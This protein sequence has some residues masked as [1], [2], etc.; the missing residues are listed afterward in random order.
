MHLIYSSVQRFTDQQQDQRGAEAD[1]SQEE[2]APACHALCFRRSRKLTSRETKAKEDANDL[3][4][5]KIELEKEKKL[6]VESATQKE[7]IL[8]TKIKSVGNIVDDSVPVSNN[9]VMVD[10]ASDS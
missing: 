10:N 7:K 3:L 8:R 4:Q 5:Q 6:T 1:R 9:E 2:G